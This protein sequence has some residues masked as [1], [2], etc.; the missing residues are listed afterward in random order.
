[1][2]VRMGDRTSDRADVCRAVRRA[3]RRDDRTAIDRIG[4]RTADYGTFLV[5]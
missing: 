5:Y 1:M 2:G 4:V 3:I